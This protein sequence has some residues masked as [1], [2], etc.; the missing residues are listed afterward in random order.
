MI[1]LSPQTVLSTLLIHYFPSF[2]FLLSSFFFETY[3]S[4]TIRER[5]AES[6]QVDP[7]KVSHQMHSGAYRR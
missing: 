7:D 6:F 1:Y 5:S 2:R 3:I 4:N